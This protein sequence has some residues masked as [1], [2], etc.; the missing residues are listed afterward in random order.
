MVRRVAAAVGVEP[1][2]PAQGRGVD[3][4]GKGIDGELRT[5]DLAA[6]D[7]G[8]EEGIGG[9]VVGD[10]VGEALWNLVA[11][12][13]HVDHDRQRPGVGDQR[14]RRAAEQRLRHCFQGVALQTQQGAALRREHVDGRQGHRG[15]KDVGD[16]QVVLQVDHAVAASYPQRVMD[17]REEDR[18]RLGGRARGSRWRGLAGSLRRGSNQP[19][20]STEHDQGEQAQHTHDA[21]PLLAAAQVR[22]PV[23]RPIPLPDIDPTTPAPAR[24][25]RRRRSRP[26]PGRTARTAAARMARRAG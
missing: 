19:N 21:P 8:G 17:G 14:R 13:H 6:A 1:A 11:R 18:R 26:L 25:A 23:G 9:K 10:A 4:R 24:S 20:Q 3:D 12:N 16:D 15:G 7:D 2:R 5:D 22:M